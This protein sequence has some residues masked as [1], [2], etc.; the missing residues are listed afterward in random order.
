[1]RCH[2]RLSVLLAVLWLSSL[3][4]RPTLAADT[5]KGPQPQK[6][7]EKVAEAQYNG[8]SGISLRDGFVVWMETRRDPKSGPPGFELR[9][10]RRTY[11]MRLADR[12]IESLGEVYGTE[13][14]PFASL[15]VMR[16]GKGD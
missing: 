9:S 11:R 7:W 13:Y 1:M 8:F 5:D 15:P 16:G 2:S 12:K 14:Q 10:W 3:T 4:S 6:N